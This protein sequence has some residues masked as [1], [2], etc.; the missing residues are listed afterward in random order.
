MVL[1]GISTHLTPCIINVNN[2]Y[3]TCMSIYRTWSTVWVFSR[4]IDYSCNFAFYGIAPV[5]SAQECDFPFPII[6][7]FLW[8]NTI[9]LFGDCML[10][11]LMW[12]DAQDGR[13]GLVI[14]F[15][16]V[17]GSPY[18]FG[19]TSGF[20]WKPADFRTGCFPFCKT[21]RNWN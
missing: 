19:E 8:G 2:M 10:A 6:S 5:C 20:I 7:L 11:Y 18:P 17:L 16:F 12:P 14:L 4:N 13:L 9:R 15:L 3:V 1:S 21:A